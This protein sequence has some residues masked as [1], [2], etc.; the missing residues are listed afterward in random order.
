MSVNGINQNSSRVL[1]QGHSEFNPTHNNTTATNNININKNN[2][3]AKLPRTNNKN[4]II[5][6]NS[7]TTTIPN[8][9]TLHKPHY[10][11]S[12]GG[13]NPLKRNTNSSI[14]PKR[15]FELVSKNYETW[16]QAMHKQFHDDGDFSPFPREDEKPTFHIPSVNIDP[17]KSMKQGNNNNNFQDSKPIFDYS[18]L[19]ALEKASVEFSDKI[20]QLDDD[21]DLSNHKNGNSSLG[22]SFEPEI[23]DTNPKPK[24]NNKTNKKK[25]SMKMPSK[26]MLLNEVEIDFLRDKIS[27][28]LNADHGIPTKKKQGFSLYDTEDEEGLHDGNSNDFYEDDYD[29][30]YDLNELDDE[31]NSYQYSYPPTHHIEVELNTGPECDVH[32]LDGCDC[33][34]YEYDRDGEEYDDDEDGPSCEFTFEYDHTGKLVPTYNN[35]EEKLRLMN[36]QSRL[37]NAAAVASGVNN[38]NGK[39][40]RLPSIND[41]GITGTQRSKP[42]NDIEENKSGKSKSKSKSKKKKKSKKKRNVGT[43]DFDHRISDFIKGGNKCCVLCEYEAIF[44]SK[45]KQL[46]KSYNQRIIQEEKRREDLRRKLENVKSSAQK[47]QRELREKQLKKQQQL[48]Q[49]QSNIEKVKQDQVPVNES[50]A[51]KK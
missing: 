21:V 29:E 30:S 15:L 40:L 26:E 8:K 5:S 6:D 36:L 44:G 47:R 49:Q 16:Q 4:H 17:T 45:P 18:L 23:V 37:S 7:N 12:N 28:M 46:I 9:P 24:T 25:V 19:E 32:G 2:N 51:E 1:K 35:V 14:D 38:G 13:P 39:N 50:V 41:L 11:S 34:I 42:D 20:S 33:P 22:A 3:N 10:N 48:Q 43:E 27:Q 31:D